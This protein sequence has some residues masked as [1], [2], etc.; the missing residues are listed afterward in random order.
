MQ[1]ETPDPKLHLLE[2]VNIELIAQNSIV[3]A[4]K[5]IPRLKMSGRLPQ[6][7]LNFSDTKYKT[8]MRLLDIT[9][10]RFGDGDESAASVQKSGQLP[11][12]ELFSTGH[13]DYSMDG[14][15]SDKDANS[16]HHELEKSET[17]VRVT[18]FS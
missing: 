3:P 16:E 2:R 4:A 10:P 9:I 1:S 6:L 11:S 8:L 18:F 13:S 14:S 15:Q 7:H 17:Q 5:S 12:G